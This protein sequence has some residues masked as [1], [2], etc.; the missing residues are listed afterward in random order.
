MNED[1]V[2]EMLIKHDDDI[3][4]I[5][6]NMATKADLHQVMETQDEVLKFVK[7]IDTEISA[8]VAH[9]KRVDSEIFEIKQKVASLK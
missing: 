2:I 4:W 8:L 7:K 9:N 3:S 6:E 5:K 1:K